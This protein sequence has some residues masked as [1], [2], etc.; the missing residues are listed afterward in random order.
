MHSLGNHEV[1][2]PL[3]RPRVVSAPGWELTRRRRLSNTRPTGR[4]N[5]TSPSTDPA[6]I[7]RP[8]TS[9]TS[10]SSSSDR[11]PSKPYRRW[12]ITSRKDGFGASRVSWTSRR[13][14][15]PTTGC[16]DASAFAHRDELF[17]LLQLV[18]IEPDATAAER[19]AARHWL[20][21]SWASVHPWGSG[22]VYPN[23]PDPDLED[24]AH[25]YHGTNLERL[26]RVKKKY[27]PDNFFRFDQSLPSQRQGSGAP[28]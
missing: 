6:K 13:G 9:S 1:E 21:R 4:P 10:P 8:G 11:C 23:W 15:A 25:A 22:V 18:V 24:W 12:W 7:G 26:V 16:A 28:A 19:E 27:D 2:S 20:A 14:P 17:V 3:N 5:G